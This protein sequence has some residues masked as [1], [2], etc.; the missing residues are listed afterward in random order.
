MTNF[1]VWTC[2]NFDFQDFDC[3]TIE[4]QRLISILRKITKTFR[5]KCRIFLLFQWKSVKQTNGCDG[6]CGFFS[7]VFVNIIIFKTSY[8]ITISQKSSVVSFNGPWDAIYCLSLYKPYRKQEKLRFS[9][10]FF[11]KFTMIS[12]ALI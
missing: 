2:S 9:I 10:D 8:W 12:L 4:W 7:S 3:N 5:L 6:L 1:K 11:V